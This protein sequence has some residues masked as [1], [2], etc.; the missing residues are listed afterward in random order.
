MKDLTAGRQFGRKRLP[1]PAPE[2][3]AAP[4]APTWNPELPPDDDLVRP[5]FRAHSYARRRFYQLALEAGVPA[6]L[7]AMG[8][9]EVGRLMRS[10]GIDVPEVLG[11]WDTIEE[12]PWDDLPDR[13]VLKSAHGHNSNGVL[14]L[15]RDPEGWH[16]VSRPGVESVEQLMERMRKPADLGVTAPPYFAEEFIGPLEPDDDLLPVEVKIYAFYGEVPLVL[17]R[18]VD[19]HWSATGM[20]F[21]VIDPEGRDLSST[22][23]KKVI[24]PT[25]EPPAQ[26]SRAVEIGALVS[27]IARTPFMRSD[28]YVTGDRVVL[29]EVSPSPGGG[30]WFGAEVDLLLGEAWERAEVRVWRDLVEAAPDAVGPAG[31]ASLL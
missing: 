2:P 6:S 31:P 27:R 15:R 30:Q 22:Y 14:P 23:S 7:N 25:I 19:R 29:G 26:L 4:P 13:V 24:D 18:R 11:T 17:L 5:S 3:S 9:L 21:R 8:K 1:S 10:Y 12:I 16:L 28:I 20:A